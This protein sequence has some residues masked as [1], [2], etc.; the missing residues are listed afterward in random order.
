[1]LQQKLLYETKN[2]RF[3][4]DETVP[5]LVNEW[6]GFIKSDDFR[7][8]ILKLVD[9]L[10]AYRPQYSSLSMLADTRELGILTRADVEWVAQEVNPQYLE[11]GAT[12]EA[13]VLSK[14]EFGK[15]SVTR[16]VTKTNDE[17]EFVVRMFD[18]VQAAKEWLRSLRV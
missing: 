6:Y 8:A 16:Y 4:I 1:M 17:G 5:C 11:A 9:L 15:L 7:I 14:D 13:F 12:H 2:V 18:S 3:Y 10:R